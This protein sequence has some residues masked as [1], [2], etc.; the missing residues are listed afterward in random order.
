ML[1]WDWIW[2]ALIIL[3]GSS[4]VS[5]LW[6]LATDPVKVDRMKAEAALIEIKMRDRQAKS[7]EEDSLELTRK[8]RETRRSV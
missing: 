6:Q 8:I 7:N 4:T 5:G 2:S 1:H 3:V